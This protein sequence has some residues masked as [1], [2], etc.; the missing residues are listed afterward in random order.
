[1]N[2]LN[3]EGYKPVVENITNI[4]ITEIELSK[5]QKWIL[6]AIAISLFAVGV[7]AATTI[8]PIIASGALC[9]SVMMASN[10]LMGL[11]VGVLAFDWIMNRT[12]YSNFAR[13]HSKVDFDNEDVILIVK[14]K[15]DH[16]GALNIMSHENIQKLN[17]Q[18]KYKVVCK[19]VENIGE[20]KEVINEVVVEKNN[21][22]KCL[23][24]SAHGSPY[25]LNFGFLETRY[26]NEEERFNA[27]KRGMI[28]AHSVAD[29]TDSFSK[30]DEDAVVIL[31]AC[32]TGKIRSST[33]NIAQRIASRVRGRTVFAP[34]EDMVAIGAKIELTEDPITSKASISY[35]FTAPRIA[36]FFSWQDITARF[37]AI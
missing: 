18:K 13:E 11:S 6:S 37:S 31:D 15:E 17:T 25:S 12:R 22:I 32:S 8:P 10:L 36:S 9:C 35:K 19:T 7:V 27:R 3:F 5:K 4:N 24:L 16:N 14:A 21:R 29:L 28:N 30:L 26:S 1:M 23:W 2:Y 20:I 33:S 34:V